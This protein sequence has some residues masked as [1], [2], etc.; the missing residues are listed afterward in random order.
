MSHHQPTQFPSCPCILGAVPNKSVAGR[1]N[2]DETVHTRL[3][4]KGCLSLL[5]EQNIRTLGFPPRNTQPQ[6]SR[7]QR[8][9]CCKYKALSRN[10]SDH[11]KNNLEEEE[12]DHNDES[13]KARGG[14]ATQNLARATRD[15]GKE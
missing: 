5:G 6:L 3:E 10:S 2:S 11:H 12:E 9:S 15:R 8:H 4:G 13:K 14:C 1:A 7:A